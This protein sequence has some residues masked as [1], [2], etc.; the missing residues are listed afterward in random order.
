MVEERRMV[1][2]EEGKKEGE[3]EEECPAYSKIILEHT[4]RLFCLSLL[5]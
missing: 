3:E 5:G 2:M 4:V 1:T